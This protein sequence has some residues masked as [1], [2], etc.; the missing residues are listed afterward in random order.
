MTR[1]DRYGLNDLPSGVFDDRIYSSDL[2]DNL[3]L[4]NRTF[5]IIQ[6]NDMN[7]TH[8]RANTS[9]DQCMVQSLPMKGPAVDSIAEIILIPSRALTMFS[10]L[11]LTKFDQLQP[12]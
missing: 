7:V 8:N 2:H 10:I 4:V 6:T 9:K 5:D 11:G 3:T 12:K 1:A